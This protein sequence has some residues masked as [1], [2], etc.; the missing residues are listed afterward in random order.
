MVREDGLSL[1]RAGV[2]AGRE[3]LGFSTYLGEVSDDDAPELIAAGAGDLV[4]PRSRDGGFRLV[5]VSQKVPPT[6]DD[7]DVRAMAIE[8]IIARAT[9]RA[10]AAHVEWHEPR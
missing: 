2:M 10:V 9:E 7:P 8:R 1:A 5:L 4:G 3:P 6:A